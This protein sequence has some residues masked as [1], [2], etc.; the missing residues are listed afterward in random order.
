MKT[1][2]A[3][4]LL[5]GAT[6]AHAQSKKEL[7]AKVLQLQRPGIEAMATQ[8]AQA[9]VL[10]M[11]QEARRVLVTQVPADKRDAAAKTIEA[12]AK[13]FVEDATPVIRDRALALAPSTA[14]AVLEDKLTEDELKQLVAW[15]ESPVNRKFQQLLPEMNNA[16]GQKIAGELAPVLDPKLDA[17]KQKMLA[18]LG[19]SSPSPA[20]PARPAAPAKPASK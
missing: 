20:T 12:D 15:L 14:G 18:A 7:V 16:L 8:M 1:W 3:V 2:I 9:P 10:Q 5:A 17:L 13:K 19:A 4:A 11:L 6:L